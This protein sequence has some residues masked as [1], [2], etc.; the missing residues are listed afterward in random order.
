MTIEFQRF[1]ERKERERQQR[2]DR[3]KVA[4]NRLRTAL[5]AIVTEESAPTRSIGRAKP[6]VALVELIE[7]VA[8]VLDDV[9]ENGHVPVPR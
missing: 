9:R 4:L 2:L 6:F 3:A 5:E 7:V 8:A 1:V